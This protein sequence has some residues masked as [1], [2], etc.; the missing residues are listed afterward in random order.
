MNTK[1]LLALLLCLAVLATTLPLGA[2]AL[3]S[4]TPSGGIAPQSATPA[5]DITPTPDTPDSS[6]PP[7]PP[8][9]T[10]R[11]GGE[12]YVMNTKLEVGTHYKFTDDD[13]VL[14]VGSA[15]DYHFL[16]QDVS[17]VPTL[18]I[19]SLSARVTDVED[20]PG[21]AFIYSTMPNLTIK[22]A[23][24]PRISSL[25]GITIK[26]QNIT[27]TGDSL[28][29]SNTDDAFAVEVSG[30]LNINSYTVIKASKGINLTGHGSVNVNNYLAVRTTDIDGGDTIHGNVTVN[31]GGE[32]DVSAGQV[33]SGGGGHNKDG[34]GGH[35]IV[36]ILTVKD[37]GTA[38]VYG[39]KSTVTGKNGGYAVQR[40]IVEGGTVTLLGG[41]GSAQGGRGVELDATIEG[42]TVTIDG[43]RATAG[44][45]G[46][47]IGNHVSVSGGS[48]TV[49]GSDGTTGNGYAVANNTGTNTITGGV[50]T[51]IG[52]TLQKAFAKSD[53]TTITPPSGQ[54]PAIRAGMLPPGEVKTVEG[55]NYAD[56]Y[57]HINF[58]TA[59]AVKVAGV[60]MAV[61]SYYRFNADGTYIAG[62]ASN[63]NVYYDGYTLTLNNLNL[64]ASEIGG[65]ISATGDLAL[66]LWGT[67]YLD[68]TNTD[69][70][71]A[72]NAGDVIN[73][74]G[75]LNIYGEGGTLTGEA[76]HNGIEAG[77]L[78]ING[79]NLHITV[80][81]GSNGIEAATISADG[82]YT[83]TVT[84]GIDY[85]VK[86]KMSIQG[87]ADVSVKSS[88][89]SA[90]SQ[91]PT[92]IAGAVIKAGKD[93]A[94][95]TAASLASYGAKYVNIS[96]QTP[97]NVTIQMKNNS[98]TI[99]NYAPQND[100]YYN[101]D[102]TTNTLEVTTDK[103]DYDLY[104][105]NNSGTDTLTLNG[106]TLNANIRST[107]A[108][109][110]V[111]IGDNAIQG[112]DG[113]TENTVYIAG[114][115]K[116]SGG[117]LTIKNVNPS[118]PIGQSVVHV[119]ESMTLQGGAKVTVENH[120]NSFAL[121]VQQNL[122]VWGGCELTAT[123][124][125]TNN[126]SHI[127][128]MLWNSA[129]VVQE[130]NLAVY[131]TV[132]ATADQDAE[133]EV[134]SALPREKWGAGI[135]MTVGNI[136]VMGG[137]INAKSAH[138]GTSGYNS[139]YSQSAGLPGFYPK[140]TIYANTNTVI[141]ATIGTNIPLEFK[142]VGA[143][144]VEIVARD[145]N[146]DTK[147]VTFTNHEDT[148]I[149]YAWLKSIKFTAPTSK[150]VNNVML[151]VEGMNYRAP[152]NNINGDKLI[153]NGKLWTMLNDQYLMIWA[154]N[155]QA[156][157]YNDLSEKEKAV[158]T[159]N[160]FSNL[161]E[162]E[163][164]SLVGDTGDGLSTNAGSR[165][166]FT[167]NQN[168]VCLRTLKTS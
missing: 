95:A 75:N 49:R 123:I 112:I 32:I 148:N 28:D 41:L 152:T 54:A 115:A 132:N 27:L 98:G 81:G 14:A 79:Q 25:D 87:T 44:K 142:N 96:T 100:T 164:T 17:G 159:G 47:G 46:D 110:F 149:N 64:S 141:N 72:D 97:A 76:T 108:L 167:I 11:S 21:D 30:D 101:V 125:N 70:S 150:P 40:L 12:V 162:A 138:S 31:A 105:S 53:V 107:A 84:G 20:T 131:G 65:L 29:I 55:Y 1:K 140:M 119:W 69:N 63:Y 67:N 93:A 39:G 104:F 18:T 37:G 38:K 136:T 74:A 33:Q 143:F 137:T 9:N 166:T 118:D 129:I 144:G 71:H 62:S 135:Y 134:S 57:V 52:G 120:S 121:Q 73:V 153:L 128:Q 113:S 85:G 45:G 50:V 109:N 19:D 78:A 82:L 102:T 127:N 35:G 66:A 106:V 89:G 59:G 3:T 91:Q 161:T 88:Y 145:K 58:V 151:G 2:L 8:Q 60:D 116:F 126:L 158:V 157:T 51:A 61:G 114:D 94:T 124:L 146:D 139:I 117:S 103:N 22:S 83:L 26:G 68:N 92:A 133:I 36:G 34:H 16:L 163:V 168:N 154:E 99:V 90:F 5:G 48:L 10:P 165:P 7:A 80:K 77:S 6:P 42:G 24:G 15:G 23:G 4:A 56:S 122:T 155:T 147:D 156:P 43:D 13:S 86:G 160:T 130:G 111:L